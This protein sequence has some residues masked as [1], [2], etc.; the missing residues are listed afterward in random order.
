MLF[1]IPLI[2]RT[3][4]RTIQHIVIN[5]KQTGS[6]LVNDI[7]KNIQIYKNISFYRSKH[8]PDILSIISDGDIINKMIYFNNRE[9]FM[10]E[11]DYKTNG[12]N[13]DFTLF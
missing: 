9:H 1:F 13:V 10:Y 11:F 12:I 6:I 5:D 8:N 4:F 2:K 3:Q 7:F